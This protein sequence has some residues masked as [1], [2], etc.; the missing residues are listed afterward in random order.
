VGA[1]QAELPVSARQGRRVSAPQLT[2]VERAEL[3]WIWPSPHLHCLA[4]N[5][6]LHGLAWLDLIALVG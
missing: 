4:T 2:C 6:E 5:S 1:A 3:S